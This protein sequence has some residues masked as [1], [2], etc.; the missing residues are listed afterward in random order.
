MSRPFENNQVKSVISSLSTLAQNVKRPSVADVSDILWKCQQNRELA[1]MLPAN[2]VYCQN[3]SPTKFFNAQW[4]QLESESPI[5]I[6]SVSFGTDLTFLFLFTLDVAVMLGLFLT[7]KLGPGGAEFWGYFLPWSYWFCWGL[8]ASGS[9]LFRS[10]SS[11]E[12]KAGPLLFEILPDYALWRTIVWSSVAQTHPR[13][14]VSDVL[15]RLF[16]IWSKPL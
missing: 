13:K 14:C 9:Y 5:R 4:P 16:N 8:L 7:S 12:Q 15:S 2:S 10:C 11:G 6:V 3:L 1:E